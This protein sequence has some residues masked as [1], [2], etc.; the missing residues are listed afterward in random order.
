MVLVVLVWVQV[1]RTESERVV[2]P[3]VSHM[4]LSHAGG[5]S[6]SSGGA[7][8][9]ASGP[10]RLATVELR[11]GEEGVTRSYLKFWAWHDPTGHWTLS[12]VVPQPHG[13]ARVCALA[14]HPRL[15]LVATSDASGTFKLWAC[16]PKDEQ[17]HDDEQQ[18]QEGS[19]N[20][21]L[22]FGCSIACLSAEPVSAWV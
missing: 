22:L 13:S 11:V 15:D 8:V 19:S 10:Q 20:T 12:A 5:S 18:Q 4:A 16:D 7:M 14:Y 21:A 6:S 1:S 2:P 17:E 3:R 9:T